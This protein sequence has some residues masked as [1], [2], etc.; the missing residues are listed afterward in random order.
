MD[1]FESYHLSISE[2][3][4]K[5]VEAY[6]SKMH[7]Y[8]STHSLDEEL[9]QDIETRVFEKLSQAEVLD[10]FHIVQILKEVGEPEDIFADS[11]PS[12]EKLIP[13]ELWFLKLQ[14]AGWYR[15]NTQAL[16]LGISAPLW[17]KLWLWVWAM[18]GLW[19]LAIFFF[20]LWLWIYFLTGWIL[21]VKGVSYE[22]MNA[23][24]Y[25]WKQFKLLLQNTLK[26]TLHTLRV[27]IA[28]VWRVLASI[29]L[30]LYRHLGGGVRFVFFGVIGLVMLFGVFGLMTLASFKFT[31]F[32]YANIDFTSIFPEYAWWGVWAGMLAGSIF[33][34]GSLLFA[35]SRKVM[36]HLY[37]F[38]AVVSSLW[39]I[40]FAIS[41]WWSL[42]SFFSQS[43]EYVI[44]VTWKIPSA[45]GSILFEP[46]IDEFQWMHTSHPI[47][48]AF[49]N[50]TGS[51]IHIR[52]ES[53]ITWDAHSSKIIAQGQNPLS[54]QWQGKTLVLDWKNQTRF[55]QKVPF[56]LIQDRL[57]ISLPEGVSLKLNEYRYYYESVGIAPELEKYT[58][59]FD[60]QD[61]AV[62][63][64]KNLKQFVA[65]PSKE[66]IEE[67]KKRYLESY[68][69]DHFDEVTPIHHQERFKRS[70]Y[71]YE[72]REY[73]WNFDEVKWDESTPSLLWVGYSD[74]SMDLQ[75]SLNVE[76]SGDGVEI[77][78]VNFSKVDIHPEMYDTMFYT[79][80]K[81]IESFVMTHK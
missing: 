50:A 64:N 6:L 66:A 13:S 43:Q 21:P 53:K 52:L 79:D 1:Q 68:V 73:D 14:Q 63:Y 36:H 9:Y 49:E 81:A 42:A 62:S 26:N 65:K 56:P 54:L 77:S 58:D 20:G 23:L 34:V 80:T 19:A 15:D 40:F 39:A 28:W 8:V 71:S 22:G 10:Q 45:S 59:Y 5:I 38:I 75:L 37:R 25:F 44:E 41:T 2:K 31:N 74:K 57:V 35:F 67:A 60:A 46:K 55:A 27:G 7:S 29:V 70:Y 69:I 47:S 3:N 78:E 33:A 76:E 16:V 72:N 30:F 48:V 32:S 24:G 4:R 11:V 18:R 51:E 12:Q 17:V 61:G